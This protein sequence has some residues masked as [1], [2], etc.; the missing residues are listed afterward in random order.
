M[1]GHLLSNQ[2]ICTFGYIGLVGRAVHTGT[3]NSDA[4]TLTDD[5][6]Q[7]SGHLHAQT[8]PKEREKALLIKKVDCTIDALQGGG[9]HGQLQM[10]S[11]C[12]LM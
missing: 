6:G 2:R 11:Y 7:S 1:V 10:I 5:D 4:C 12:L 9:A 8:T 3:K